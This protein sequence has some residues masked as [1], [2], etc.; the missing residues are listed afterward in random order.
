ML[1]LTAKIEK[2]YL[3]RN[4]FSNWEP[5]AQPQLAHAY[6]R[7]AVRINKSRHRPGIAARFDARAS[8]YLTPSNSIVYKPIKCEYI[9][10]WS[11]PE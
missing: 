6:F 8:C 10:R 5:G 2:A 3:V 7:S 4:F 9:T 1:L 11:L